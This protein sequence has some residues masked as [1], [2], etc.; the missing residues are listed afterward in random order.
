MRPRAPRLVRGILVAFALAAVLGMVM[1]GVEPG[2]AD[3]GAPAAPLGTG[4][5]V[6]PRVSAEPLLVLPPRPSTV[7]TGSVADQ[8]N[9]YQYYG[10]EPAPFGIA[11]YGVDNNGTVYSYGT[12]EIVGTA[13]IDSLG[14]YAS[15]L[16]NEAYQGTLQLNI[17][18]VF[19]SGSST[20]AYWPQDVL[21]FDSSS[22]TM[23]FEDNIWNLSSGSHGML[24]STV[25]G[26]GSVSPYGGGAYYAAGAQNQEGNGYRLSYPATVQLRC[27]VDVSGG[28]PVV[29]FQFD[30]GYGWQTYDTAVFGFTRSVGSALFEVDGAGYAPNGLFEDA[31]L[32]FGGPGDGSATAFTSSKV[33]LSLQ[34]DNGHNLQ[35]VPN[36][37]DFGSDTA[38]AVSNGASSRVVVPTTGYLASQ[39]TNGSGALGAVYD[40][41]YSAILNGSVADPAGTYS[42]DG[43]SL[44][45][46]RNNELN[47][48]LAPGS[49]TIELYVGSTLI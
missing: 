22:D 26:N 16:G 35:E 46:F 10:G 12:D 48:T 9:V 45:T 4:P 31:E 27:E 40:R 39:V 17:V 8:V 7:P 34:F 13:V 5:E 25:S 18:L 33:N 42:I 36:A 44:G 29:Y 1:G 47:L 28:S 32:V 11:D 23:E 49:Y 19:T 38:E 20:F 24:T 30:D 43:T 15:D 21:F 6:S 14:T 2:R 41:G 3:A 37:F